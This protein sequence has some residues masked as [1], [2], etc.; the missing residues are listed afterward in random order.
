MLVIL[1]INYSLDY[2]I[3]SFCKFKFYIFTDESMSYA[4]VKDSINIDNKHSIDY[5]NERKTDA[6]IYTKMIIVEIKTVI[7]RLLLLYCQVS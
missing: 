3:L 6:N 4:T 7:L 1:P 5:I 2:L